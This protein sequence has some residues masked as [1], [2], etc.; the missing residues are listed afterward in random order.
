MLSVFLSY[1]LYTTIKPE[2]SKQEVVC[3]LSWVRFEGSFFFARTD[4]CN[5]ALIHSC[6]M[7][8]FTYFVTYWNGRLAAG[9]IPLCM[10]TIVL[11]DEAV[12]GRLFV[13]IEQVDCPASVGCY[14]LSQFVL[15]VQVFVFVISATVLWMV[16]RKQLFLLV[17]MNT[18]SCRT[19]VAKLGLLWL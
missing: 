19:A 11:V 17:P 4:K 15:L 12:W 6:H 10:W 1:S 18:C 14:V 5:C 7:L 16:D 3:K 2:V 8:L 9:W 13:G